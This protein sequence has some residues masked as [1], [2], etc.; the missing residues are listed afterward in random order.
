MHSVYACVTERLEEMRERGGSWGGEKIDK[1]SKIEIKLNTLGKM[2]TLHSQKTSC[3]VVF[4]T[5]VHS[6][7]QLCFV[8][9]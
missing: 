5:L 7:Q 6:N 4:C 8:P 3:Q 1:L 9:K 2:E